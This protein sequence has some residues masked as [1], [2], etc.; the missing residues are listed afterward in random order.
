MAT[1]DKLV[2][3]N[4]LKA[5]V[6]KFK[7]LLLGKQDK[8]TAGTGISI[9]NN[10]ISSTDY[11]TLFVGVD[12]V[13]NNYSI[14]SGSQNL[15]LNDIRN[16]FVAGRDVV[17]HLWAKDS[18]IEL[19]YHLESINP[20]GAY[21]T[22]QL[23]VQDATARISGFY[24]TANASGTLDVSFISEY[25]ARTSDLSSKQNTITK[26]T[27]LEVNSIDVESNIYFKGKSATIGTKVEK[28][29]IGGETQ[30]QSIFIGSDASVDIGNSTQIISGRDVTVGQ[31]AEY[32]KIG[33]NAGAVQ[34]GKGASSVFIDSDWEFGIFNTILAYNPSSYN[35]LYLGN[36]NTDVYIN[37]KSIEEWCS[38]SSVTIGTTENYTYPLDSTVY[39][40]SS[41]GTALAIGTMSDWDG[42]GGAYIKTAFG[43]ALEI[44]YDWGYNIF[45]ASTN[46]ESKVRIK[47]SYEG[48]LYVYLPSIGTIRLNGTIEY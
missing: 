30:N 44:S 38:G 7:N 17:L 18:N 31:C 36:G 29:V 26:N 12:K 24:V 43:T 45:S 42:N 39:A 21:F 16:A 13:G 20:W 2:S 41:M 5:A 10:T 46:G 28:I 15:S 40:A 8:L 3:L 22:D 1:K 47:G 27:Q 11:S 14:A 25:L 35:T 32:L 23:G 9:S 6:D 19:F 34:I 33:E 48:N 4:G 37:Y